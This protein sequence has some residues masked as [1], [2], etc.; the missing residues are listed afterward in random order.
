MNPENSIKSSC[1]YYVSSQLNCVVRHFTFCILFY[2]ILFDPPKNCRF[3]FFNWKM[4]P[5]KLLVFLLLFGVSSM[6]V[7]Q[8]QD[9]ESAE[10]KFALDFHKANNFFFKLFSKPKMKRKNKNRL[11][12]YF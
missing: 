8:F 6:V 11:K 1:Y 12:N 2:F 10:S 9:I 7:S 3:S 5:G 4:F